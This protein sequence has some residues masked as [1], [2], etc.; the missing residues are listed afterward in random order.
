MFC[1]KGVIKNL[2]NFTGKYL[3]WS[4]VLIKLQDWRLA[5]LFK[6]DSDTGT[7]LW[8]L[9]SFK[10]NYFEEYLWTTASRLYLKRDFNAGVF[11]WVLWIIQERLFYTASE[12][13]WFWNTSTGVSLIKLQAWLPEGLSLTV[14][15]RNSNTDISN[16]V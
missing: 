9:R 1:K 6:K 13:G 11:L 8:N 10:K 3:C 2:A 12:N 16:F 5:A 14:L 15:E 4:L 7:L